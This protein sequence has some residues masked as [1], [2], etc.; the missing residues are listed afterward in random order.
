MT[1]A[2]IQKR[3]SKLEAEIKLIKR[4]VSKRPD[5]SVGGKIWDERK[6]TI[7]AGIQEISCYGAKSA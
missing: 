5:F 6:P 1:N 7:Q 4:A 2:V 3:L